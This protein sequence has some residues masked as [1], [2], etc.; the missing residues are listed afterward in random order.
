[1]AHLIEPSKSAFPQPTAQVVIITP[2][3]AKELLANNP[4]NRDVNK[5]NLLFLKKQLT[6]GK[7]LLNGE[8]IKVAS[9][10]TLLDGQHRLIAC[11]E[12][13][14]PMPSLFIANVQ[15]ETMHT[16]DTGR[17]RRGCDVV[18]MYLGKEQKYSSKIASVA[19]F[20]MQFEKGLSA[21]SIDG[22]GKDIGPDNSDYIDFIKK[23]D[24]FIPF[25]EEKIRL[26]AKGDGLI[27]PRIFG[28]LYWVISKRA[29]SQA[30]VD[31]FFTKLSFGVQIESNSPIFLLRQKLIAVKGG[32]DMQ[33][34]A[35]RISSAQKIWSIVKAW[36]YYRSGKKLSAFGQYPSDA[37]PIL[38]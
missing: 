28:G 19:K 17:N 16:I 32:R 30:M 4:I 10:G 33:S 7:W 2:E 6:D 5:A 26:Y 11:A 13:G 31:D 23:T 34:S 27:E 38:K 9:D 3:R 25:V 12:S 29:T 15:K 21:S 24:G 18:S 22:G 36:N 35:A 20:V 37:I 8:T 14:I 1:M